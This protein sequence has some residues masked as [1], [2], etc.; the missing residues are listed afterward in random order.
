MT[1]SFPPAVSDRICRHMNQDHSD[2]VARYAQTFGQIPDATAATMLS[3]DADG[4]NLQVQVGEVSQPLRIPFDHT[5]VDAK[6]AHQTLVAM[7]QQMER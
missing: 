5:L 4:M 6:D 3:I 1:N 7:L 2:A